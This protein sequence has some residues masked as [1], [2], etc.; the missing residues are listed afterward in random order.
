MRHICVRIMEDG[1][2]V[3][4]PVPAS[5]K[6][7]LDFIYENKEEILKKQR[8]I[9][10]KKEANH[11]KIQP[12]FRLRTFSFEVSLS[13][14]VREVIH[15][16]FTEGNLTIEHPASIDFEDKVFQEHCWNGIVY[17]M[18]KEA[19]RILP[20]RTA[21]LATRFGFTYSGVKIQSGKTRWGSCSR[22]RNINLSLYLMLLPGRL[23][24]Y[25]ILHELC[26]TKEMNHSD[27]FWQWMD[28]V[29]DSK[30]SE[31]RK[32]LKKYNMP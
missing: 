6:N 24:D 28:R 10:Q 1:L 25:V 30:S 12:G 18:R 17:F 3:S 4:V 26:H 32:E 8:L 5:N 16:K 21:E 15:F 13:P 29:T 11:L 2:R 7:A 14:S 27:R 19:R 31:L 23:I 22:G 20:V 9:R